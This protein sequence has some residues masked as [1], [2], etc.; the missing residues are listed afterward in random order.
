MNPST[1]PKKTKLCPT[2]GTQLA[3]NASRCLVCGNEFTVEKRQQK[4]IQGS[5][6]P[7]LRISLP[8]ALG[9]LA[10]IF[11][12]G[13]GTV[14]IALNAG[15][16]IINPT[17]IPTA[18]K[19]ATITPTPTET[20][21]PSLTPTPTP[22]PPLEYTVKSGD[23]CYTIAAAFDVSAQS[24]ILL[25]NLS[26]TCTDLVV[27]Q[28]LLI[29]QPTPTP[30]PAATVT[31]IPADATRAACQTVTITVQSTDT[32]SSISLNYG[33]SMDAI[34]QWNGLSTDT[35]YLNQPLKIPL[36]MRKATPGPSPTPTLPPPYPAPN[37]LL[38]ANGA[39]FN[40]A[41]DVVTLQWASIGN[42]R[43]NEA[44]LVIVEDITEGLGRK[45][46]EYVA[47]TKFIVPV[48]FR[49]QDNAPHAMS[50]QIVTV[51]QT[52]TDD[53]G[54]TIWSQAGTPSQLRVFIWSGAAPAASPTP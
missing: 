33:V 27:G 14:Y 15:N 48:S 35:V 12:I 22:L 43:S 11:T 40:L 23:I 29:P 5:R 9:L 53:Q 54:K 38:P 8:L 3:E 6:M 28:K 20:P 26:A 24:I 4:S 49:P 47:D 34:K 30:L 19:T 52:G 50:W 21:I 7:V 31:L 46:N 16:R 18:T 37:L 32:L 17:P 41:N 2:C 45:L 10:I 42:L 25:N 44:Y 51:R 1:S 36:C 39:A 13:A